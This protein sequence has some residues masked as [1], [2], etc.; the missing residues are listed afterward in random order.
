M[1][2][3]AQISD[4]HFGTE[5]FSV[6]EGLADDLRIIS[7]DVIVVSGDLTQRAR[8]NQFQK[9]NSF[10]SR[11]VPPKIII[12]GNHDIPLFDVFRRFLSPLSRYN[13][14]VTDNMYPYYEDTEIAVLG[15][16]TARSLVWKEGRISLEQIDEIEKTL[17]SVSNEKFKILV[18]HHPF[19]PP[20][21]NP[22][23]KIV[24]RSVLALKVI[25]KC[26]IDLLL[27]G[28]LHHGYSGDIRPYYPSAENSVISAQ[29]GT[30]ISRRRRNEPNAYNLIS[31][32]K[33]TI[34]IEIRTWNGKFFES[35][36]TT[37]YK[38]VNKEWVKST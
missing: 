2:K 8:N 20:P 4:L 32:D 7:P 16:N 14:F 31:A 35:S 24:G 17:C 5:E 13:R 26:H 10:L 34:I 19:I 6:T 23:I 30:A 9:A 15:I 37:S 25:A 27:A 36:L 38:L 22:G 28:H 29:A 11:L 21:G 12:P 1:K 3:I 33:N 18:T